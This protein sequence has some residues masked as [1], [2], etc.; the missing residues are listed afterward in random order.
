MQCIIYLEVKFQFA[1]RKEKQMEKQKMVLV[2]LLEVLPY[3]PIQYDGDII[4]HATVH[5]LK[6]GEQIAF[7]KASDESS[8]KPWWKMPNT[9]NATGGCVITITLEEAERI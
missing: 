6:D 5:H 8:K 1:I 9:R 3:L 4:T 7:H 2:S